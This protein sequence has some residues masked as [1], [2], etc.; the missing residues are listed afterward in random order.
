V[1][2]AFYANSD[3]TAAFA[4]LAQVFATFA[5]LG[6]GFGILQLQVLAQRRQALLERFFALLY[7][8]ADLSGM[9]IDKES[10]QSAKTYLD[11]EAFRGLGAKMADVATSGGGSELAKKNPMRAIHALLAYRRTT[12][13]LEAPDE[14]RLTLWLTVVPIVLNVLACGGAVSVLLLSTFNGLAVTGPENVSRMM[15][16]M[17]IGVLAITAVCAA[18]LLC[19]AARCP[20]EP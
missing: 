6:T 17:S 3:P 12:K 18:I 15:A 10:L 1:T 14:S 4:A 11:W 9:E 7:E 20:R 16:G 19:K 13:L 8:L 5:A 2:S